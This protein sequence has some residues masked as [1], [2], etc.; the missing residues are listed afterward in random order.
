VVKDDSPDR[1]TRDGILEP[2]NMICSQAAS[3]S[4]SA[5]LAVWQKPS[6]ETEYMPSGIASCRILGHGLRVDFHMGATPHPISSYPRDS[7]LV[8]VYLMG[9]FLRMILEK[10]HHSL[11]LTRSIS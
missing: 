6:T 4:V 10:R 3:G 2:V 5:T 11:D 9:T 1:S 8:I 7:D